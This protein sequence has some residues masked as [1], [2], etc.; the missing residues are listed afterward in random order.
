MEQLNKFFSMSEEEKEVM[1][2]YLP[3]PYTFIVDGRGEF[4]GKRIGVRVP[5]HY[6]SR[7]LALELGR[8]VISTS[9][10]ISGKESPSCVEEIENGVAEQTAIIVDG[11]HCKYG[12]G[13][14]VVDIKNNKIIR[15]G[16]GKFTF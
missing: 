12:E 9:A 4:E 16:A 6:F 11:G 1:L 13:S 15:Q 2:R 8:P 7:K 10:N 5:D 14:T 3:G